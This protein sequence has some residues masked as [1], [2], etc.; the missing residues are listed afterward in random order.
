MYTKAE[1]RPKSPLES[2]RLLN[3]VREQCPS[4]LDSEYF[5]NK[6]TT[7]IWQQR[8]WA[9]QPC[10]LLPTISCQAHLRPVLSLMAAALVPWFPLVVGVVKG[11]LSGATELY[12]RCQKCPRQ[13]LGKQQF[14]SHA[15]WPRCSS[16]CRSPCSVLLPAPGSL[17]ALTMALSTK[18]FR[19][20]S[21]PVS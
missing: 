4:G 16:A 12:S 14:C 11:L 3:L 17:R 8:S 5:G 15:H 7:V 18:E 21:C 6:V 2:F 19:P 13:S 10:C 9:P 1:E 20:F